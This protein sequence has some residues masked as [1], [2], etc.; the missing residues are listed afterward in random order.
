MRASDA[1]WK[2]V[3]SS[4]SFT[5]IKLDL[6]RPQ[7]QAPEAMRREFYLNV[8]H[9]DGFPVERRQLL[10]QVFDAAGGAILL[11][12]DIHAGFVTQHSA[13]TVEFTTPAVS[14]QTI[15]S[16]LEAAITRDP[17]IA[18]TGRRLV[19]DL[20][21]TI[22]A[23]LPGLRYAQTRR[24]GV[25][26]LELEQG[27]ARMRFIEA[28]ET[29]CLQNLYAQPAQYRAQT[30]EQHFSLDAGNRLLREG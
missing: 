3:A 2:L 12:G 17:A 29:A 6:A 27:Q 20:D 24:H 1:T 13:R 4:V 28:P 10:E 7:L 21:A 25:G 23:G 8:D 22:M 15:G 18:D 30:R 9:W 26:V 16:I 5:S 14:S 11:S 19:E